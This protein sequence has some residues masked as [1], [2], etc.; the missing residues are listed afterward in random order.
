MSY[1]LLCA[2]LLSFGG[3]AAANAAGGILVNAK[4]RTMDDGKP[5]AD[6]LAWDDAGRIVAVG[7]REEI[8]SK[9]P[10]ATSVDANGAAVVPGLIDAHAHVLGLGLSLLDADLRGTRS[11]AEI[12]ERLRAHAKLLPG[13]AWVVGRGWDQNAWERKEFPTA[14]D[15]DTAFPDRPVAL[16]RIDGHATWINT[17]AM[18]KIGR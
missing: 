3:I 18:H 1:R 2:A 4:I 15:L 5:T 13:K 8:A 16:E 17:A 6:A 12:L 7:T 10:E 9:Y 14:A 11:K